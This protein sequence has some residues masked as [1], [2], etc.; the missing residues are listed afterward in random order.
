ML[1]SKVNRVVKNILPYGL[2]LNIAGS[3]LIRHRRI[4]AN[5]MT[6]NYIARNQIPHSYDAAI[7]FLTSRWLLQHQ[8]TSGSTPESS[9]SFCSMVL[10]DFYQRQMDDR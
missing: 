3:R 6:T 5:N 1:R 4:A 7:D 2:V 10:D 9:L 8:V